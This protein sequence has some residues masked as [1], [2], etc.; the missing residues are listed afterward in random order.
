[1]P[2]VRKLTSIVIALTLSGCATYSA[3]PLGDGNGAASVAQLTAP[4]AAMSLATLPP[5]RFDP[6]DGLD[7]TEVATLAVANSPDL[8]VKRDALGVARAQAFAAGLLP[9]PQLSAGQDFPRQSGAGLTSA[10]SLGLT[11]DIT[12]LL[13]RS[14]RRAVAN[15]QSRQVNLDLLWAEWQTVAQARLLFDQV[16]TLRQLQTRLETEQAVLATVDTY[17]NSAL[18]SG[19]LTYDIASAGL[20]AGADVQKRLSDNTVLLHQAQSDLHVLL[21][22][23]PT[24]PLDLVGA[25]YQVAPTSVQLQQAL[26]ELPQ[27]RPDLLALQA[28]YRSQ[29]AKLR[30]AVWAQFPAINI[31]FNTARDTSAIYTNGF[32]LGI[33]LPL[34]DRNRGNIAIDRATRQQLSDDYAARV[35]TTRS[36]MHRLLADITTLTQQRRKLSAHVRQLDKALSAAERSW[37][38]GLLDWPTYLAIRSNALVADLDLLALKQEQLKQSIALEALLGNTDLAAAHPLSEKASKP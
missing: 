7:V 20:N 31:G 30:A 10:F 23:A 25:P 9:D 22:L 32:T 15:S 36:D 6:S 3:S 2:H 16:L 21:G 12:A 26:T 27:R 14:M 29:E 1:M 35:L 24:A 19:N 8:R 13:T 28:G 17:I 4:T 18:Q 33:T 38:A 37:Q 34:F 5:H 11:E